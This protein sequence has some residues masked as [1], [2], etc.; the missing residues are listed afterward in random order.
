VIEVKD[1][2]HAVVQ[3]AGP[4]SSS[5]IDELERF[6]TLREQYER[7]NEEGS[8][9]KLLDDL[10]IGDGVFGEQIDADGLRR[11]NREIK[12]RID[13]PILHSDE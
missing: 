12:E 8:V 1:I 4:V 6:R 11:L 2:C 9:F 10:D 13:V 7:V 3:L 5:G